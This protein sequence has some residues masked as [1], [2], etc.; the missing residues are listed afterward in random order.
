MLSTVKA[1]VTPN[2]I[3]SHLISGNFQLRTLCCTEQCSPNK[4]GHDMFFWWDS[5]LGSTVTVVLEEM[6]MCRFL[7]PFPPSCHIVLIGI[8]VSGRAE[9]QTKGEM[10]VCVGGWG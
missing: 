5:A 8:W 7:F 3:S 2:C 6:G 9:R 10:C 4:H 1:H